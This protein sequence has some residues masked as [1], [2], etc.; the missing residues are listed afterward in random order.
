VT[1]A[2][3]EFER[4][5]AVPP[6]ARTTSRRQ[7]VGRSHQLATIEQALSRAQAG[8][9]SV[10][11]VSGEPGIG[12]TAVLRAVEARVAEDGGRVLS[13]RAVENAG[14]FGVL[15]QALLDVWRAS[16]V[17]DA[18]SLRPFRPAVDRVLPGWLPDAGASAD[19][20]GVDPA[21]LLAEGVLQILTTVDAEF[22]MLSIDDAQYADPDTVAVL[23]H[24]AATVSRRPVLVV[25]ARDDWPRSRGLDRIA[26]SSGTIRLPLDRLTPPDLHTLVGHVRDLPSD[27]VQSIVDRSEGLPAVAVELAAAVTTEKTD[28]AVPQGFAALVEAR[29]FGLDDTDRGLLAAAAALGAE[30]DWDLVPG[31]ARVDDTAAA[32]GL[33]DAIRAHLLSNDQGD[34]RWRHGLIRQIVWATLLPPERRSITRAAAYALLNRGGPTDRTRAAELLSQIGDADSAAE[35]WLE[36]AGAAV[37]SGGLRT[38]AD[39]LDRAESTDRRRTA[40]AVGRVNL[41]SLTGRPVEALD[42]GL[43]ALADARG[44]EHAELC[45]RLARAAGAA[46]RWAQTEQ[47]VARAGRPADPRSATLLSDAAHATGRMADAERYAL[48]AV[49]QARREGPM[50]VL[51]EALCARGRLNR[52][53]DL[54][55]ARETFAEAAQLAS[56]HGLL[57]WRVEALFGL[58]TI[59]LLVDEDSPALLEVHRIAL[60][61]GLLGRAA[62]AD[63]LLADHVLVR[64]G[65]GGSAEPAT[66]V[67]EFGRLARVDYFTFAGETLLASRS[68][69][70]GDERAMEFRLSRLDA[71]PDLPPDSRVQIAGVRGQAALVRHDLDAAADLLDGA[72]RPLAEHRSAAPLVL[73]GAWALVQTVVRADATEVRGVLA[74]QTA[75]QRRANVGALRYVDA[76]V[77]GRAG[78]RTGAEAALADGDELLAPTPWWRRFLR[79]IALEAAV[80]ERWGDAVPRLRVDL[81]AFEAAGELQLARTVRDLLR[82]AGAPTRRGRGDST[83]PIGLRA[84]GV[85]SREMDVLRLLEDGLSNVDIGNR[86]FLSPR[87]VETHVANLLSKSGASNRMQLVTWARSEAGEPASAGQPERRPR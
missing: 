71:G 66:R 1:V 22:G 69:L 20:L 21:L 73:F 68:A 4:G 11:E 5:D 76:V 82:R 75:G 44:E 35:L 23:E 32:S 30:P 36:L 2:S 7:L 37:D 33:R 24:C 43:R 10:V 86:L 83:V 46:G 34:L 64:D 51:C 85:T 16:E 8:V 67:A 45:F 38:A 87:T 52:L 48:A 50:E 14:P 63:L 26:S 60:D 79:T 81:A 55:S 56:E 62:Q 84:V 70:A 77:A 29:L 41:L 59:D 61:A 42:I 74:H 9:G 80:T 72:M 39:L 78:D 57:P 13:G 28:W 58:A 49:N 12:K 19:D 47:L 6:S 25:L 31:I 15:A 27:T 3:G 40:V 54:A 53:H 17:R 18:E 65:P